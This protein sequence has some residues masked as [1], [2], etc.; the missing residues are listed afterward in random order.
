[1]RE[2]AFKHDRF[3]NQSNST[4]ARRTKAGRQVLSTRRSVAVSGDGNNRTSRRHSTRNRSAADSS[5][6]SSATGWTNSAGIRQQHS[7]TQTDMRDSEI[8][9]DPWWHRSEGS[10]SNNPLW[11]DDP[12]FRHRHPN[13]S[14]ESM[15]ALLLLH[16]V[17]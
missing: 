2:G 6:A 13:W 9:T 14:V 4:G 15:L 11:F 16:S 8:Q 5:T 1:M 3:S 12:R 7:S 17:F 10:G